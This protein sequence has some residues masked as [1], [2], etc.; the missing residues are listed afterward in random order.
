M[1][2]FTLRRTMRRVKGSRVSPMHLKRL[3]LLHRATFF[4]WPT[5][6]VHQINFRGLGASQHLLDLLCGDYKFQSRSSARTCLAA[7][8]LTLPPREASEGA[9][10]G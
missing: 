5:S 9:G 1:P 7:L 8:A 6:H 2:T 4:H 3:M 10:D